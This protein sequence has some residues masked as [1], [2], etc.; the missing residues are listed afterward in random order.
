ML[1]WVDLGWD[2]LV[3]LCLVCNMKSVVVVATAPPATIVP[4][5]VV[6]VVVVVVV[7]VADV[8]KTG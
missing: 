2:G 1:V 8:A 7:F 5:E 3:C 4:A 6:V